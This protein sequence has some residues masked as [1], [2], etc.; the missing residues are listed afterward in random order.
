MA[1]KK[2]LASVGLIV[3]I[4]VA[5]QA[6]SQTHPDYSF[7]LPE[8]YKIAKTLL[9]QRKVFV[10]NSVATAQVMI[11]GMWLAVCLAFPIGWLMARSTWVSSILQ[12]TFVIIKSLPML[13]LAP[14]MILWF[15]WSYTSLIVP[16]ALTIFFPLTLSVYQGMRSTPPTL[17]DYFQLHQAT[18]WQTF[19]KLQLPWGLPHVF[20]GLRIAAV[21]AGLGAVAGE[22]AG[23][24]RGLGV[25]MIDSRHNVDLRMTFGCLFCLAT[26]SLTCYGSVVLV[27]RGVQNRKTAFL[28]LPFLLTGLLFIPD[29]SYTLQT[30]LPSS[31]LRTLSLTLDWLPNPNHVPLFAGIK[32]HI[33]EKYGFRIAIRRALDPGDPIPLVSSGQCDLALTYFPSALRARERGAR[34]KIVGLLI[35]QPLNCFICRVDAG[36][37]CPND[38]N[39]KTIGYCSG[40]RGEKGL[41]AVLA[42]NGIEAGQLRN[43]SFDL[44]TAMA[45]KQVD[46][47]FGAYWNIEPSQLQF[48]GTEVA[49]LSLEQMQVPLY[50]ELI[51][52]AREETPNVE[53]SF[54]EA[55]RRALGEAIEYCRA[56]PEKAF[57][58]YVSANVNKSKESLAWERVSWRLTVPVLARSQDLEMADLYP[59]ASWLQS[60][61]L[62]KKEPKLS[63]LLTEERDEERGGQN[64]PGP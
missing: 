54:V 62:L 33:F 11:G 46:A 9:Q 34:L 50:P 19:A 38:L 26:L 31:N 3:L 29:L 58:D 42:D 32:Q 7:I 40:T 43:V 45:T 37:L 6:W 12:P 56:Y 35:D 61:Q 52:V 28:C 21:L 1:V 64:Q 49:T 47:I 23:A 59:F 4:L 30:P 14:L 8:P 55:F 39:G 15:G 22:W 16:T 44:V 17:L 5:W 10:V 53:A 18:P 60:H 48:L 24:Q 20:A 13:A 27:E 63:A 41:R 2:T 57:E 25:L 51:V 36:I